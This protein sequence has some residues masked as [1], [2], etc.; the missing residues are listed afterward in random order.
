MPPRRQP[1]PPQGETNTWLVVTLVFF[2]LTT[3]TLGAL[4]FMFNSDAADAKKQKTDADNEKKAAVAQRNEFELRA[5][6]NKIYN[7][8][9]TDKEKEQF[10]ALKNDAKTFSEEVGAINKVFDGYKVGWNPGTES[11]TISLR[12]KCKEMSD[13]LQD[14]QNKLAAALADNGKNNQSYQENVASE[15]AAKKAADKNRNTAMENEQ[16]AKDAK[17]KEFTDLTEATVQLREQLAKLTSDKAA[18]DTGFQ[19][20]IKQ[21]Q[22]TIEEKDNKLRKLQTEIDLKRE[23]MLATDRPKG[24]ITRVDN[25]AGVAYVNIGSADFV[26]PQLTFSIL[27]PGATSN[28][29]GKRERKGALEITKVLGDKLS[30]ARII[31]VTHPLQD[32]ILEGD[33]I[34][35]PAWDPS[36]RERVAIA[37][38]VDVNGDGLDDTPEV[39]RMLERQGVQVDAYLDLKSVEIKGR[40]IG[41][42]TGVLI[43]GD[44]PQSESTAGL[45]ASGEKEKKKAEIR[46]K[47]QD[48][49]E[50]ANKMGVPILQYRQYFKQMGLPMS[51]TQ[52]EPNFTPA[53]TVK[54]DSGAAAAP[55]PAP[56]KKPDDK[57]K[58]KDKDKDKDEGK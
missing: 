17:A 56:A 14:A 13:G 16:K 11:P 38:F 44:A 29:A 27:S 24:K 22:Q 5:I 39:V 54:E 12:D 18:S 35:N 3:I 26:R 32:P 8:T 58:D 30:Q 2:I 6:V 42:D 10:I 25:R 55:A 34:Y 21:L 19:K 52:Q 46:A 20:Q 28:A 15:Q 57:G 9:A 31:D 50:Q 43:L 36:Q 4:C 45:T 48:M 40:G 33:L 47:I 53:G 1:P 7:G 37:G 49:K 51:R 23:D 41:Y